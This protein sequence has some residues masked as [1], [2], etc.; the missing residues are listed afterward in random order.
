[1]EITADRWYPIEEILVGPSVRLRDGSVLHYSNARFRRSRLQILTGEISLPYRYRNSDTDEEGTWSPTRY[2]QLTLHDIDP[3]DITPSPFGMDF[4]EKLL[5]EQTLCLRE[6]RY[7]HDI[8]LRHASTEYRATGSVCLNLVPGDTEPAGDDI[9]RKIREVETAFQRGL[10]DHYGKSKADF[11]LMIKPL[12]RRLS[13]LY[14][15]GYLPD[16]AWQADVT[17]DI[18]CPTDVPDDLEVRLVSQ[19]RNRGFRIIDLFRGRAG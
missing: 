9:H 18:S 7:S 17:F 4:S 6:A 19:G 5:R 13:A 14:D 2:M 1:M 15:A 8:H 10:L 3:N 12:T 11:R 16:D